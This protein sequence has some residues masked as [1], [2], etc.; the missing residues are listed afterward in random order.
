[1]TLGRYGHRSLWLN[2]PGSPQGR[3]MSRILGRLRDMAVMI[4]RPRS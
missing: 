3:A 4:E 2:R 1:M